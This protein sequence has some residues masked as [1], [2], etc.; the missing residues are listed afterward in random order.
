MFFE[1]FLSSLQL[2][3]KS[4]KFFIHR[5]ACI[6]FLL[7]ILNATLWPST[8]SLHSLANAMIS[9]MTAISRFFLLHIH[10]HH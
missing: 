5:V 9:K 4:C 3:T 10:F 8:F 7:F 6:L 1:F 2:E